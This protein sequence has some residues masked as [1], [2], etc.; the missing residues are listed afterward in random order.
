MTNLLV[1]KVHNELGSIKG[2][3]GK[4]EK[5]FDYRWGSHDVWFNGEQL[6]GEGR[7]EE[8]IRWIADNIFDKC[9]KELKKQGIED[10]EDIGFSAKVTGRKIEILT[11]TNDD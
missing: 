3:F 6:G 5:P 4:S 10:T 2:T 7:F 1:E 9:E 8:T 11:I